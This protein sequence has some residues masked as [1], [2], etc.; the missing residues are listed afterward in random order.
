[1]SNDTKQ[2]GL[3]K[4]DD[5]DSKALATIVKDGTSLERMTDGQAFDLKLRAEAIEQ[6]MLLR[7]VTVPNAFS[8]KLY[9]DGTTGTLHVDGV[10]KQ[11]GKTL[12][13]VFGGQAEPRNAVESAPGWYDVL[14]HEAMTPY[15]NQALDA[16]RAALAD[17]IRNGLPR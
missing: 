6:L 10:K 15:L 12:V 3:V 13:E 14:A 8:L 5:G 11:A 2:D 7:D 1:M 9:P 16:Y 17:V 4:C